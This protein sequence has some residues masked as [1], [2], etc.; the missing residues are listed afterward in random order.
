MSVVLRSVR[1]ALLTVALGVG[2]LSSQALALYPDKPVTIVVPFAPGGANDVVVRAIQQPF[3][4]ALGQPIIVEN[5][6]GAGGSVG[7]GYVARAR[8][9]R[10]HPADGR[11]RLCRE[12]E[13]LRQ[14]AV[15]SLE[16]FR[17]SRGAHDLSGDLHRAPRHGR[18]HL[19][20][21]DRLRQGAAWRAQLFD[22]RRRHAAASRGRVAQA[23]HRH[24]HG[25]HP[26]SGR[27]AGRAGAPLRRPSTSPRPRS[28]SPSRRSKPAR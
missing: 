13:P 3:A 18:R 19:A 11:H 12:P 8:N 28:R 23:A 16:G 6:G 26:L 10:L 5:R 1:Y 27:G 17:A 9:R 7:A 14:G 4:E 2:A 20:G 21:T 24:Q 22:A 25:A 15:R